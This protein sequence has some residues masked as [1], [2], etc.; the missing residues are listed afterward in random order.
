MFQVAMQGL[1][2]ELRGALMVVSWRLHN[3]GDV[4]AYIT[5]RVARVEVGGHV[6]VE[7]APTVRV[8]GASDVVL[9]CA[10]APLRVG[11]WSIA[12][13]VAYGRRLDAREEVA[14]RLVLP[15]PLRDSASGDAPDAR[16]RVCAALSL[17]VGVVPDAPSLHAAERTLD[18]APMWRLGEAAWRL[19]EV[20]RGSAS[21]AAFQVLGEG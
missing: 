12:P 21:G 20:V 6:A 18:G 1:R 10:L 8:G 4:A 16:P 14:L 9:R 19:Q 17:E 5:D 7:C 2:Y 3:R 15:L 11:A 13:P